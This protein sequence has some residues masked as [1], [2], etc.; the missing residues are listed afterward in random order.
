M[1][2]ERDHDHRPPFPLQEP[3]PPLSEPKPDRLRGEH[4]GLEPAEPRDPRTRPTR[5]VLSAQRPA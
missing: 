4:P 2:H 1:S 5:G 3:P